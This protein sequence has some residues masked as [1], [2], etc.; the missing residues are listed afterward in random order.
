M[1][2]LQKHALR[3]VEYDAGF[4]HNDHLV[5]LVRGEVPKV[6]LKALGK[7]CRVSSQLLTHVGLLQRGQQV[8][9]CV[10]N[11]VSLCFLA[12][13]L[14]E[15]HPCTLQQLKDL[16]STYHARILLGYVTQP[17]NSP[18]ATLQRHCNLLW[19]PLVHLWFPSGH[20]TRN[21]PNPLEALYVSLVVRS[22]HCCTVA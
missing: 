6:A 12:H 1:V 21:L 5:Q 4:P 2:L 13:A 9:D 20:L 14:L 3:H 16:C 11:G 8:L 7:H 17:V 15:S 10:L 19:V 22:K 18:L